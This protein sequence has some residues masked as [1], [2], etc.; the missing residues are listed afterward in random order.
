MSIMLVRVV[1]EGIIFGA[2]RNIT[3][4]RTHSL[5]M[6]HTSRHIKDPENNM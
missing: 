3:E 1:P 6:E 2:D 4:S 5:P